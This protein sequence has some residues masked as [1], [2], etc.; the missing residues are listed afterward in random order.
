[1]AEVRLVNVSK[2]FDRV[3]AVSDVTIAIEDGEFFTLLGPSGCGKT[4]TLRMIAG[5]ERPTSG[6]V[7]IG[8]RDV[9]DLP[10]KAR[11]VA[12]VFQNY[13]LY[14]HMTVA[15]NIGYPLRIRNKPRKEIEERTMEVA[16]SLAIAD[17]VQR[18]PAEISG[19][20]Q[21][22]AAL[23]RA[24]VHE[25][26]VFLFDE[27]LSNLDAK[28]RTDARTFLKHLRET[29][30]ITTVYVTH[31]Q[32]EAMAMSDRIA[33]MDRGKVVQV[34]PPLEVYRHPANTF[35]AE[36]LGNPP[37]NLIRGTYQLVD[38]KPAVVVDGS[39]V[40][41]AD[42]QPALDRLVPG[43]EVILGIRPEDLAID[44]EAE[45]SEPDGEPRQLRQGIAGEVFVVEPLGYE[46]LVSV[47]TRAGTVKVKRFEDLDV[48]PGRRVRLT[49]NARRMRLF[50]ARGERIP[51]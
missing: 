39:S 38:G 40:P 30:G 43:S 13:A 26:N 12:M 51:C 35:V 32:S 18:R 23:A 19:G 11:N 8:D 28:L 17:L 16:R 44:L 15:E 22:R 36:F 34:G 9:T 14:P 10:P 5:L 20:Q 7:F 25:P 27:P 24:I 45:E 46:T 1:M 48:L 2:T 29:L 49:P 3:D 33:V 37:M 47:R 4:T 50:D 42:A 21:Q 31:D 41:L 6:K